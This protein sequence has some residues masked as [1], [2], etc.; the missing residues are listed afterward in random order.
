MPAATE[1]DARHQ[2]ATDAGAHSVIAPEDT[3]WG[4]RRAR[5]LDPEGHDWSIGTYRPSAQVVK[6]P[7]LAVASSSAR[8]R[9]PRLPARLSSIR[10][11]FLAARDDACVW[12]DRRAGAG[13]VRA[14]GP[15]RWWPRRGVGRPGWPVVTG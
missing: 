3:A 9:T 7:I 13:D 2:R 11:R 4:T 12:L 8:A 1:V 6:P 15:C 10:S 14:A 5:V